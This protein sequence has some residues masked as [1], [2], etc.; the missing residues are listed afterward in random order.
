M[1]PSSP[2]PSVSL[3]SPSFVDA[4]ALRREGLTGSAVG[5]MPFVPTAPAKKERTHLRPATVRSVV[6]DRTASTTAMAVTRLNAK[7]IVHGSGKVSVSS[8]AEPVCATCKGV[9]EASASLSAAYHGVFKRTKALLLLD[10]V[11]HHSG[12]EAW[13]RILRSLGADCAALSAAAECASSQHHSSSEGK[14]PRDSLSASLL[15]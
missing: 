14:P 4:S 10:V 5:R 7:G 1:S 13:L 8:P 9:L 2:P 12:S 3:S 6:A 11:H 15:S